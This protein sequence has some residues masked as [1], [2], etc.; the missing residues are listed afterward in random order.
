VARERSSWEGRRAYFTARRNLEDVAGLRIDLMSSLRGVAAFEELW[1]RRTI[2]E[3]A[4][5]PI[6]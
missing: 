4:G 2:I 5:E 6:D 1:A 3:V